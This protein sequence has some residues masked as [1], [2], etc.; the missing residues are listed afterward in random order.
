MIE[1]IMDCLRSTGF[2]GSKFTDEADKEI[3][4]KKIIETYGSVEKFNEKVIAIVDNILK[5]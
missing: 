3:V 2:E 5:K 4:R 1:V